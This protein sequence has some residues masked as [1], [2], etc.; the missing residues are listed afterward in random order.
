[1]RGICLVLSVIAIFT[2]CSRSRDY[3]T[4]QVTGG[5][6]E[7]NRYSTLDQIDTTN[8]KDL[9]VA[10]VY[11]T[12]D[13]DTVNHS[14]IQCNPIIVDGVMYGTTPKLKLFAIDAATGQEKWVYDPAQNENMNQRARFIMNNNRGVTYWSDEKSK[15]I[16]FTA[17][18]N[19][20]SVDALTGKLVSTFGEDGVVDLHEGLDRDVASLFVVASSPGIIYKDLLILGS[21]V[22]EGSDAAP[23]HIRAFDVH[24]GK[25]RWIFHTIPHP[26]EYGYDTWEDSTAYRNIG[27]ANS[28]SGFSLDE[29]RGIVFAPTGSASF[30][31]FGGKRKGTNL[32]ANSTIALD[33]ATGKY[34]WHFQNIHH[35]VW[36]R[37]LPPPHL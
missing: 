19:L 7:N 27:G 21:R 26:G 22:S 10:W 14:Q 4:W 32:F 28:W 36:D 25:I 30:D 34:L 16:F 29:E 12:K 13:A 6:K 3:T 17:G 8:V 24:T 11:H 5:S 18:A 2:S 9:Q 35:D 1:M 20:Y 33:A 37:D 15:R 23:G 31:F